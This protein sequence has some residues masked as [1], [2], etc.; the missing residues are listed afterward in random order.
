M[1]DMLSFSFVFFKAIAQFLSCSH[2]KRKI[3]FIPFRIK[4]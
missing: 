3:I 1:L 2:S 4:D